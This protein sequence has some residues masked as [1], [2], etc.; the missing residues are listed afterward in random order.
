MKLSQ[1]FSK[2]ADTDKDIDIDLDSTQQ[3]KD[4]PATTKPDTDDKER[5]KRI[6]DLEAEIK[7]LRNDL[8]L[9]KDYNMEA[10]SRGIDR[11]D[12]LTDAFRDVLGLKGDG[13][14]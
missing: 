13:E 1:I 6:A 9:A 11:A 14:K 5:E 2:I 7:R 3:E 12:D 8:K 10:A 4:E